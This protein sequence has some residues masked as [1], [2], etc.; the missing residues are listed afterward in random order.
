MRM[1]AE[2][3]GL[4]AAVLLVAVLSAGT[5]EAAGSTDVVN[6]YDETWGTVQE[7]LASDCKGRVVDDAEADA[8]RRKRSD[9]IRQVLNKPSGSKVQGRRLVSVGSGF[10]IAKDGTLVTNHHVVDGCGAVSIS[11]TFGDMML[12]RTVVTDEK[13]DLA[14]LRSDIKPPRVA[15]LADSEDV[16]FGG[17][18]FVIGYPNMGL[19]A[20]E[21]V[22]TDVELLR[23]QHS[24]K[25]F[26]TVVIRGDIRL[27][28]SGGP[29]LDSGGSVL[30]VVFAKVDTV[31]V[32]QATGEVVQQIALAVANK[33]L[34]Q[35]LDTQGVD[36]HFSPPRPPEL[37]SR[38]LEDAKPFVAQIGC[39]K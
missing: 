25:G 36:Y 4:W 35:F 9:Y 6:C 37:A 8:I 32:Y 39:W 7:T 5:A 30:G 10:F 16:G 1:N 23:R 31:K 24:E 29:L 21:P 22:L 18:A 17:P 14:L 13:A 34:T 15:A 26:P 11:P 12:A 27:G 3:A 38:M 2:N 19:V 28:N 20:I 33:A